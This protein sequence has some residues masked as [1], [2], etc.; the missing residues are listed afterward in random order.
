MAAPLID[1]IGPV[2]S[3]C[4]INVQGGSNSSNQSASY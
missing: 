2:I 1:G 4:P 3:L